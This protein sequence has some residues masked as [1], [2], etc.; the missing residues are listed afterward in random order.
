MGI[1]RTGTL[2]CCSMTRGGGPARGLG[3]TTGIGCAR[4]QTVDTTLTETACWRTGV[5]K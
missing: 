5:R 3:R 2:V 4:D 1:A